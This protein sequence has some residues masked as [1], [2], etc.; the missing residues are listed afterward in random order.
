MEE[1]R[2]PRSRSGGYRDRAGEWIAAE[3]ALAVHTLKLPGKRAP[4]TAEVVTVPIEVPT[5]APERAPLE[6]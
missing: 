1:T 4:F 6:H 2:S 5:T 3:P